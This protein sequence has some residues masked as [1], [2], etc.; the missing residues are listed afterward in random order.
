MRLITE[1]DMKEVAKHYA[2]L[3][4]DDTLT[5]YRIGF[6]D[7]LKCLGIEVLKHNGKFVA[8]FKYRKEDYDSPFGILMPRT[9]YRMLRGAL[10][11]EIDEINF[12]IANSDNEWFISQ[13]GDVCVDTLRDCIKEKENLI[14]QIDYILDNAAEVFVA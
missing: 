4:N 13:H 9:L 1:K 10:K 11:R 7:A 2:E 5:S 6:E 3:K 8:G 12:R 14:S